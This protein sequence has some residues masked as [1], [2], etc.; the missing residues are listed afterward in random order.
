MNI[1]VIFTGGTIGSSV[2]G[3]YIN[4]D[5]HAPFRLLSMYEQAQAKAGRALELPHFD[6]REPYTLLSENLTGQDLNRLITCLSD[7]IHQN[8]DGIIVTH[9]TDTLQYTAAALSLFFADAD[10][11]ILLV[12]SNYILDDTKANGLINFEE[13][14]RF[15]R[16]TA[17]QKSSG[18]YVSYCNSGG[19][20]HIHNAACLLPHAAYDDSLYSLSPALS[21]LKEVRTAICGENTPALCNASTLYFKD[22]CPVLFIK[23]MPGQAYPTLQ[24]H[25]KAVLIETY[26]SGTLCTAGSAFSD[27]VRLADKKNI[28]VYITGIENRTAYQ[29]T[30]AFSDLPLTVLAPCSPI[31]AYMLL[32]FTTSQ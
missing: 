16:T 17:G 27:F 15:I 3:N 7:A 12:S 21:C 23:A 14:V 30:K 4:T 20:P 1:L 25:I 6:T 9:G 5:S 11:P 31:Y 29:S 13:A 10:I 2:Q 8:Y 22:P 26:H 18:V 19:H 32:W 28:P 24:S